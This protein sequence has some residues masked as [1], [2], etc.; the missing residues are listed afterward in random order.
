M[1]L[2][3]GDQAYIPQYVSGYGVRVRKSVV[4]ERGP[5]PEKT[6][7]SGSPKLIAAAWPFGEGRKRTT[8][9]PGSGR[10]MRPERW[11]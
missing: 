4:T 6:P 11:L 1:Y 8:V 5:G 3:S 7:V 9:A 2:E 10:G